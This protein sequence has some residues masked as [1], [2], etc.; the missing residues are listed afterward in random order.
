M[1]TQTTPDEVIAVLAQIQNGIEDNKRLVTIE[2]LDKCA[3]ALDIF[4]SN[5][6][7]SGS[8]DEIRSLGIDPNQVVA[9]LKSLVSNDK[10]FLQGPADTV[11]KWV[12]GIPNHPLVVKVLTL[13]L[14]QVEGEK[15]ALDPCLSDA[16]DEYMAAHA[17]YCGVAG[18]AGS[19]MTAAEVKSTLGSVISGL[20]GSIPW[21]QILGVIQ[22]IL[23]LILSG[24][25]VQQ[26]VAAILAMLLPKPVP[27]VVVPG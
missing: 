22:Q 27:P 9:I 13:I 20:L 18:I 23:P 21:L 19:T 3:K 10:S 4:S 14:T 15:M 1:P 12:K 25:T 26:I 17:H 2:L 6:V 7:M 5:S 8:H 16:V 24:Q 11:L